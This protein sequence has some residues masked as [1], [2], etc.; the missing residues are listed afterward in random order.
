LILGRCGS[1]VGSRWSAASRERGGYKIIRRQQ[2]ALF[3]AQT[4]GFEAELHLVVFKLFR[5]LLI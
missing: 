1:L 4:A 2:F 3:I 5:R